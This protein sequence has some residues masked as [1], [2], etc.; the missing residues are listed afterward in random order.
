V[1]DAN[2]GCVRRRERELGV[3]PSQPRG[4]FGKAV[5]NLAIR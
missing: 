4:F 2:L 5:R 1:Y 3:L